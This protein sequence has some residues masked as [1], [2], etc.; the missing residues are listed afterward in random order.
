MYDYK[1]TIKKI[2]VSAVEVLIA[3]LIVFATEN[4]N[5]IMLVPMLEGLRNLLKYKFGVS[6]L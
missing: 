1:I 6:I 5:Y 2:A 3:G 4:P